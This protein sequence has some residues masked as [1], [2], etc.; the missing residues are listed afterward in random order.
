MKRI[1]VDL[2]EEEF[3]FVIESLESQGT[4]NQLEDLSDDIINKLYKGSKDHSL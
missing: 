4:L 2:T 1:V 3:E